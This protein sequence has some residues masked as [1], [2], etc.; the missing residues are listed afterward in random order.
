M[1]V[2]DDVTD[3][4]GMAWNENGVTTD[5]ETNGDYTEQFNAIRTAFGETDVLTDITDNTV[6]FTDAEGNSVLLTFDNEKK[7]FV[8]TVSSIENGTPS[9]FLRTIPVND[10]AK[11]VVVDRDGFPAIITRGSTDY[12]LDVIFE[13]DGKVSIMEDNDID[14]I[15]AITTWAGGISRITAENSADNKCHKYISNEGYSIVT[16]DDGYITL[17][18]LNTIG[19]TSAIAVDGAVQIFAD[20]N[21][22]KY[23]TG[24]E[25]TMYV[26]LNR[27][28]G[29]N[30]AKTWSTGSA[31]G[32]LIVGTPTTEYPSEP[33]N[34]NLYADW[35]SA[36]YNQ[37]FT[38]GQV[39][40]C[41][42]NDA[43]VS[44]PVIIFRDE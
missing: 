44:D 29:D 21:C 7:T 13:S 14:D 39:V 6:T 26:R 41:S 2:Q 33:Y 31:N 20:E 1:L 43:V 15:P 18:T 30:G 22:T 5:F 35:V 19:S 12:Y 9:L 23:A 11:T 25:Q 10:R 40:A 4:L 24:Q 17:G 16:D 32:L 28:F 38:A 37:A 3:V 42:V 27:A 34:V 8:P 36:E